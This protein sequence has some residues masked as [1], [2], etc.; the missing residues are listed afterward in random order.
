MTFLAH[1]YGRKY[2]ISQNPIQNADQLEVIPSLKLLYSDPGHIF[3][4]CEEEL[5]DSLSE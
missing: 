3:C 2:F 1:Q 5:M 4:C